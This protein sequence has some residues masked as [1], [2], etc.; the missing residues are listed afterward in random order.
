MYDNNDLPDHLAT[1]VTLYSD[2]T[3]MG[4]TVMLKMKPDYFSLPTALTNRI[5]IYYTVSYGHDKIVLMPKTAGVI[6][7]AKYLKAI[8]KTLGEAMTKLHYSYDM[9]VVEYNEVLAIQY[10]DYEKAKEDFITVEQVS[11]I[12]NGV[13]SID[14]YTLM[15]ICFILEVSSDNVMY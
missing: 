14:S 12:V 1:E 6:K 15:L 5:K 10:K 3:Y 11:D 9:V 4:A 13:I 7:K 2:I 8:G